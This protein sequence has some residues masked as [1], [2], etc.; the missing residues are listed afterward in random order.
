MSATVAE[1][2]IDTLYQIGVRQI[3]GVVGDA[4]NPLTEAIRRDK[5]IEWIG[6]R[7]EEGAAL[8]AAGQAKL[9]GRLAVCCGTTG[10]GANHLV[11][12]L[13]EARKDHAP[14]LAIS[15]GV[16][17]AR[18]GTDYLQENT[19]DILFRDVACYTQTVTSA[20]QAPGVFHQ[21]I[22][23]AYAQRGVAHLN[24]P[25]DIIGAKA[26]QPVPSIATLR[27]RAELAPAE[28]EIDAAAKLINE[29]GTVA[30]FAGNGCREA[31]DDV[32]AL[33]AKLQ[34]PVMHTFK[35]K[36]MV[37]YSHPHWIGG[38]GLIGGAP[39][40]DALHD[41]EVMLMLGSDYPYSEFLPTKN[42]VIQID[43]RGFVLGR[44]APVA[45]G[46]TG[47]VAPA[48]KQL[49]AAVDGKTDGAFLDKVNADREKWNASLDR[50]AEEKRHHK[51]IKPQRLARRLGDLA[52]D[53]A[54][55]VVDT[56][57]VTLWCGNW[58]RQS[59][60]QRILASFNNAAV[61]TSLGQANGI[62]ALER[63]RQVVVAVGD[64]GFT[65][66]LGEFMTSVEHKLPVKVVV[67][68]NQEWGLVHL[69]MEEAGLPAFEGSEFPNPDFAAF[70]QACGAQGF[71]ARTPDQ[72]D[73]G[74]A[75]LLAAPGPAV[76]NVFIDASELPTMPHIKMEQIWR[77]GMAKVRESLISMKGG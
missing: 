64:G 25:A 45:L 76:L 50:N 72:L 35:A 34:A 3:F 36:D 21:A 65:M 29:A 77:F 48:V 40:T 63:G 42:R 17:A 10:P 54:V 60:R 20:E 28:A 70:A 23:Q 8:A 31:I 68:N 73:S 12:G 58:I 13:Y 16:P 51:K 61:G 43:E 55:F 56:G 11:A 2:L 46:I 39:G 22:A 1:V 33:A 26:A 15:G 59:G 57:V 49:L 75:Q 6:V 66:L 74:I 71:T 5:R 9:T 19:P 37:D 67:F 62:Q 69:E 24:I 30:I 47:S 41:A 18:R 14:V 4:L 52:Q 38:V 27:R 53:D 44:R 7:H 32:L